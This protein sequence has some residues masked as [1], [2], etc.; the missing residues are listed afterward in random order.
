MRKEIRVKMYDIWYEFPLINVIIMC[1]KSEPIKL[2]LKRVV[3]L[4]FCCTE[5]LYLIY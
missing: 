2:I 4:V 3:S 1:I 5:I